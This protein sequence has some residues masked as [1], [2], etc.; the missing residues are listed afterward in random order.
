MAARKLA[1]EVDKCFKKVSE[2]VAEFEAIY[3]KIEQSSNPAQKDKLEDN[4]KREIKKLQRLRDQIK[5]WAASN[6]IKD[7][8]PLLEHRKL[9]ETQMEKFKAVEKA[10]KTKAYSKEGL[11]AAAKL[12]PKE[13]A[14]VE[15]S[16]FLSGMVDELEQQIET[17]EAEGES[18]QA[19][20]K[21][22]KNNTAK[23]ERIAEVERIIE[24][25][26]W[27]QGKLELI[28]RSLENGGVEPE[29][30]TDLE[31]SIRYYVSDGMNEDFMEDEEM[32]EELDLEDEEGTYGMGAD[33]EK[34]SSLD[35]QSVQEDLTTDNDLPKTLTR[36]AQK[37]ADPV[38]RTSSQTKSPLPALA[39]L[40]S[41]LPTISN[42]N[43]GTPAMKPASV[44]T[45]PAGEGLKYASA[46][47]AA[48][49][50][51]KNNVGIA[52]L[53]PPP[54]AASSSISPLPQARSSATNSP[55]TSS[56]QPASQQPE[57]KQPTPAPA[58]AEP[59]PVPAPAPVP[60]TTKQSKRS[61]AAGKQAAVPEA[62][63]SSK[64]PR[65][66]GT[67]NGVKQTEEE[68][69]C[70]Y[71]LPAS[72]QD[73]V[74]TYETSRKRPY[75]PSAPSALRM[76]TASQASCPDIV[77]ADVPRSYRPDQPVPPTGS[78]F[79]REPLAIFDDPRLYSRM[80][81]DTLFYV[82]YYKQG[83]AQQYM[84]AK[85]LKD[86]SWRFHKQYQTWFQRHEEPKNI[87][88]DFE[89]GTYRFFDY[90]STWMNRRKADFKFV[91]K[92]LE[93]EV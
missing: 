78:G 88:E 86:Q 80:D 49:A 84:A 3:E 52:P 38:R 59:E 44:P 58:P 34:N 41:P 12:D 87:T 55:A 15:A 62:A 43:S 61:K 91:Y 2:G 47:A 20:M 11:S 17:L 89:Q 45:R 67:A 66:N 19:T 46:A 92:F 64:A 90:E 7:K 82:F 85:A 18:I 32:Y 31:E 70:I 14:K 56:A 25:H 50:S 83:T 35:A 40:H 21:K 53:P 39:T 33:N 23:A 28:R 48:A 60:V 37:E 81:P 73:L 76:M 16:E 10:M 74:D 4:L 72:L 68:E 24:R 22:G 36:K 57:S 29:Q 65:T 5:T 93:D 63:S 9:I 6:D 30:V 13:Q 51:D 69:E 26:K 75:P 42:S 1:Q 79:P 27:H 8:A 54:G 77:D 71:H